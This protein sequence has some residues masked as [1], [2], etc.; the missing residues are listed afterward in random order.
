[1]VS[2]NL[3][4]YNLPVI[5]ARTNKHPNTIKIELNNILSFSPEEF[6][7]EYQKILDTYY[8]QILSHYRTEPYDN[9][10]LK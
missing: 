2:F 6:Y 9:Y 4:T 5:N 7:N 3:N 8:K 1:M 10:L